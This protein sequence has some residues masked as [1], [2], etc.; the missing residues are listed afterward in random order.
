ML[1]GSIH[2]FFFEPPSFQGN[3]FFIVFTTLY[4]VRRALLS[5]VT[6]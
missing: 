5:A 1:Q 4:G 6:I 3:S 2:D